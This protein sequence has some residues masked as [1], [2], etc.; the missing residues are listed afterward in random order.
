MVKTNLNLI[1]SRWIICRSKLNESR[2][3][4]TNILLILNT[5]LLYYAN[6]KVI[7]TVFFYSKSSDQFAHKSMRAT[8]EHKQ[9]S[10]LKANGRTYWSRRSMPIEY[11]KYIPNVCYGHGRQRTYMYDFIFNIQLNVYITDLVTKEKP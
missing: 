5:F 2:S 4:S 1:K 10:W 6:R 7:K 11:Y 3:I 8:V 9:I